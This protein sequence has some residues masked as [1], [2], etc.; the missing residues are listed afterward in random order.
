MK[1]L[2]LIRHAKSSWATPGLEDFKRPLNN[3][4]K[5]DA[6]VMAERL[7]KRKIRINAFISSPAK[8]AHKTANRFLKAYG[9]KKEDIILAENLYHAGQ[10]DFLEVIKSAKNKWDTI[11]IFSHNPGIT[12]FASSLTDIRIDNMPT[13]AV[14]AVQVNT[15]DWSG[16]EEASKSFLFFDYPK[17]VT[18]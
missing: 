11:A 16:F 8:R 17:A 18:S 14:F 7:L 1:T 2:L 5:E 12:T 9:L 10:E 6:P 13:C 15:D 4:G 3:R